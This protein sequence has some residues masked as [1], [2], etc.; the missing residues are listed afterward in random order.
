MPRYCF[1]TAGHTLMLTMSAIAQQGS[2]GSISGSV[3]D[4]SGG[5][6]PHATVK[7]TSEC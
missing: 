6:V 4:G 2:T 1:L 3:T 5:V 7:L